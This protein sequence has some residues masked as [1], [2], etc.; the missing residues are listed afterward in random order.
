MFF[1]KLLIL[2]SYI[3]HYNTPANVMQFKYHHLQLDFSV[4]ALET[5]AGDA[6]V[7]AKTAQLVWMLLRFIPRVVQYLSW[8]RVLRFMCWGRSA[9]RE[10]AAKV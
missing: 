2:Y 9:A 7:L 6:V 8:I 10:S 1:Q 4:N 3:L 5:S